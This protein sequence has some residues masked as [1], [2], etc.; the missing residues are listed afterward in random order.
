MSVC[1]SFWVSRALIR[2]NV[3][4]VVAIDDMDRAKFYWGVNFDARYNTLPEDNESNTYKNEDIVRVGELDT[5]QGAKL[6][7]LFLSCIS[8]PPCYDDRMTTE[9]SRR[10][11]HVFYLN[12]TKLGDTSA[13]GMTYYHEKHVFIVLPIS[14]VTNKNTFAHEFGHALYAS[15]NE[16]NGN[17]PV[18]GKEHNDDPVNL[19]Y[20]DSGN[21][22]RLL[23]QKQ[24]DA[25]EYSFLT[26]PHVLH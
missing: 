10:T 18:S 20:V 25:K 12:I 15:N 26:N 6:K 14:I 24:L 17:D 23:V 8:T 4:Y 2:D 1:V 11:L 16:L 5:P 21:D 7:N 3:E 13:V 22:T 9:D 19:M